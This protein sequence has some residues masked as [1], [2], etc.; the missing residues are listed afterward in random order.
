MKLKIC[1]FLFVIATFVCAQPKLFVEN[2]QHD[3]GTV[4]EGNTTLKHT[5]TVVNKGSDTLKISKV[6]ASC[7]CTVAKY[8]S[9][10]APGKTGKVS[11]EFDISRRTGRETKTLTV[12]SNDADSA[13]VHLNLTVFIKTPLDAV[14]KWMTLYS[15]KGK[16]SGNISFLTAQKDFKINKSFYA[17]NHRDAKNSVQAPI[18]VNAIFKSKS[19]PDANGDITY[20]YDFSFSKSVAEYENGAITFETNVKEKPSVST[21][22]SIEPKKAAPY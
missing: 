12:Y 11:A 5:F 2:K 14:Q 8:D 10:V 9:I 15:D 19:K 7:G 21:N 20:E 18:T 1:L 22:V 13:Q 17:A 6:N 4:A 3:W 16:I